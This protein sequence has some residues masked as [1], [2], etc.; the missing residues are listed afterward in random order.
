MVPADPSHDRQRPDLDG[1][2]VYTAAG[3]RVGEAVDLVLDLF[4]ARVVAVLVEDVATGLAETVP[5]D[6]AG[7]RVPFRYV[8]GIDD[9]VVLNVSLGLD[10]PGERATE[11]DGEPATEGP[12]SHVDA[13]HTTVDAGGPPE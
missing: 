12:E 8:A 6:A 3:N 7:V 1:V 13:D 5:A 10:R 11:G 2:P 9:A 4:E